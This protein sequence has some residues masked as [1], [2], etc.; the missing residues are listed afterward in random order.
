[1]PSRQLSR[2]SWPCSMLS[3]AASRPRMQRGHKKDDHVGESLSGKAR[4]TTDVALAAHDD[5]W[6]VSKQL[7]CKL[8]E[9][10]STPWQPI[11]SAGFHVCELCQFDAPA[12]SD[13]VFVPHRGKIYVA[14]VAILHY[15]SAHWYRPPPIFIDA[16]LTC[17]PIDS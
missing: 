17:P 7:F 12:F 4:P 11:A 14:P 1:M 13:N 6:A 10:C 2:Q 16:V 9:L 5:D 8:Q 3:P 15:I